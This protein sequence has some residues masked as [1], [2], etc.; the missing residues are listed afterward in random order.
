MMET[1]AYAEMPQQLDDPGMTVGR[2]IENLEQCLSLTEALVDGTPMREGK[3]SGGT[4]AAQ[5][6]LRYRDTLEELTKRLATINQ[7]LTLI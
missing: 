4:A 2:A 7:K 3:V 6:L 1:R 5:P